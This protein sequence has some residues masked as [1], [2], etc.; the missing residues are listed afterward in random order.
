MLLINNYIAQYVNLKYIDPALIFLISLTVSL[1]YVYNNSGGYDLISP[2][3]L[4]DAAI[5]LH[6]SWYSAFIH[7]D[8]GFLGEIVVFSPYTFF[9]SIVYKIFGSHYLVPL[10]TNSF[11]FA[12]T[13]TSTSLFTK[14]LMGSRTTGMLSGLVFSFSGIFLFYSGLTLKTNLVIMLLSF[15]FLLILHYY[16]T[17]R[18]VL[19]VPIIIIISVSAFDRYH[20]FGM[21]FIFLL[22]Q[23][24]NI[25]TDS[26]K[27]RIFR[28]TCIFLASIFV[29]L[30]SPWNTG[31]VEQE[32][33]SPVGLNYYIGNSDEAW[34]GY[35]EQKNIANDLVGHRRDLK[36]YTEKVSGENLNRSQITNY[37]FDRAFEYISDNRVDFIF[38]QFKKVSLLFSQYGQGQPEEFRVWRWKR[39]MLSIALFDHGLIISLGLVGMFLYVRKRKLSSFDGF[40]FSSLLATIIVMSIFF[41]QERY[42][43]TLCLFFIPFSA[44]AISTIFVKKN[45]RLPILAGFIILFSVTILL[46]LNV[47]VGPGFTAKINEE[48]YTIRKRRLPIAQSIYK[49]KMKAVE[50]N[51]Y[52]AWL[53]LA[54]HYNQL[55]FHSDALEFINKAK[56][57]NENKPEA[58][59]FLYQ[60][61][62][63]NNYDL[64]RLLKEIEPIY[65]LSKNTSY[66]D[67]FKVLIKL[68]NKSLHE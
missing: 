53:N 15:S 25:Y 54:A 66:N 5:Y 28:I 11:L 24:V 3:P 39:P 60:I 14:E 12:L 34:G 44:Y 42:R 32:F 36:K 68:I 58:Y 16:K 46:N 37:W 7:K 10:L 27:Q 4:S 38:L 26:N 45:I 9:I 55:G 48:A 49:A 31:K 57:I 50:I 56:S 6:R 47:R 23:F 67:E 33:F 62:K 59:F 43:V 35:V 61:H 64:H 18:V 8:G 40:Y 19:I 51:D 63:K 13:A 17:R 52:H 30:I 1:L 65:I 20:L 21:L 2:F 29:V 22:F 41:V